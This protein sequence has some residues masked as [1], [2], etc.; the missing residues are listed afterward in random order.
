[1][2]KTIL[3]LDVVA[4]RSWIGQCVICYRVNLGASQSTFVDSVLVFLGWNG[5]RL[6]NFTTSSHD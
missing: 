3:L 6:G 4:V 2:W 5:T 1:M